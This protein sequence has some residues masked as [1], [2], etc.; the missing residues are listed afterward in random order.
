MTQEVTVTMRHVRAAKICALGSRTF[1]ERHDL[2]WK[3]FVKN[4]ISS[5]RL[6]AIGDPIAL[7]AVAAARAENNGG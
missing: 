4:G 2:N 1:F 6:E 3:D 5:E 7:K